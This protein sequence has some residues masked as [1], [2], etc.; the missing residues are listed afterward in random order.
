MRRFGNSAKGQSNA[1]QHLDA[2]ELNAFAEGAVP[3]AARARYV[4]HL[5]ECD[6]CR[7]Q[8]SDLALAS[9]AIG[10]LE[11]SAAQAPVANG[12]WT[13]L[14]KLFAP[15]VIRYGALAA[16]LVLVAGVSFIAL[17]NRHDQSPMVAQNTEGPVRPN[18]VVSDTDT[19]A[20]LTSPST[21]KGDS[22]PSAPSGAATPVSNSQPPI[23]TAEK[24]AE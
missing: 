9:G 2:D 12:I 7:R 20:G 8:V 22:A 5:A 19:G 16:A 6:Q 10:R 17:R 15:P 11:P 4:S 18:A 13:A 1:T 3:P 14:A 21:T 24:R 23:V